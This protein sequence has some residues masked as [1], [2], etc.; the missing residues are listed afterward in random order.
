ML[1]YDLSTLAV[2]KACEHPVVKVWVPSGAAEVSVTMTFAHFSLQ[3]F[4]VL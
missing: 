3:W 2:L 4:C 1:T